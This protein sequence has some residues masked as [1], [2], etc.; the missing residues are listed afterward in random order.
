MPEIKRKSIDIPMD[1]IDYNPENTNIFNMGEIE[2]LAKRIEE[3]GFTSAILVYKKDDDRYEILS[4]HRRFEAMKLLNSKTIPADILSGIE[5]D[6]QR[7][8]ILLS[9]NIANRKLAPLDMARA[10]E[11]YKGIL[12]RDPDF[13]G[14]KK[15]ATAEYF[16]I[17]P[18]NVQRYSVILKLIPELQEYCKKPNFPYS[19]LSKAAS[20]TKPEQ[21][22]LLNKLIRL[23]ADER[24]ISEEEVDKDEILFSRTRVEQIINNMVKVKAKD[25][26]QKKEV[27]DKNDNFPMNEP[28]EE[29]I[30]DDNDLNSLIVMDNGAGEEQTI[31]F[32]TLV[33]NEEDYVSI[34]LAGFDQCKV[35]IE[36]YKNMANNNADKKAIKE[37]LTELKQV[38]K[39]LESNL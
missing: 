11:F 29:P 8:L 25:N 24:N 28:A 2:S 21:L 13:K 22:D 18:S 37:K 35:M 39:D 10:I 38:I 26:A 1:K 9:S 20:L 32:D 33:A 23:E 16:G 15:F 4:G 34:N 19:S 36:S 3:E 12:D 17:T 7:D 30:I 27:S 5:S 14:N 31:D 6:T